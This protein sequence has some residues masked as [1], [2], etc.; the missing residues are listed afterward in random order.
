MNRLKNRITQEKPGFILATIFLITLIF[1]VSSKK[2]PD[3]QTEKS[4]EYMPI[5]PA[6]I[7]ASESDKALAFNGYTQIPSIGLQ[8]QNNQNYGVAPRVQ[9][10][11]ITDRVIH[12]FY[13]GNAL[14]IYLKYSGKANL[15]YD[16]FLVEGWYYDEKNDIRKTLKGVAIGGIICVFNYD[17]ETIED[18]RFRSLQDHLNSIDDI[19]YF[20]A[21]KEYKE[22]LFFTAIEKIWVKEGV[23]IPLVL[24]NDYDYEPFDYELEVVKQKDYLILDSGVAFDLR[25]VGKSKDAWYRGEFKLLAHKNGTY[26]LAFN[27]LYDPDLSSSEKRNLE[28]YD[29]T[30]RGILELNFDQLNR[31]ENYKLYFYNSVEKLRKQK[32]TIEI[33]EY[34]KA[35]QFVEGKQ[36]KEGEIVVDLKNVKVTER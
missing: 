19:N 36:W 28:V 3:Y 26:I 16:T 22:K 1:Y 5:G 27:F 7:Q 25:S 20:L 15:V 34:T 2:T 6:E 23:E 17:I 21:F 29:L 30:N 13:S 18:K 4:L 24:T 12:A 8:K 9:R 11:E 33:D 32:G 31:L 35:Y 10:L 14:T